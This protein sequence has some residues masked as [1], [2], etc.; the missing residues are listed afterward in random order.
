MKKLLVFLMFATVLITACSKD[1]LTGSSYTPT[2]DGSV[3]SYQ[4]NVAPLIQTYCSGCHSNYST[5]ANLSASKNSVRNQ[6]VSGNMPR[7]SA[8]ST[9]QKDAIVCWID[10]GAPNN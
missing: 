6:I 8:L 4:S 3:K 10:N 5:Y 9:A 2:C 1:S 7:G